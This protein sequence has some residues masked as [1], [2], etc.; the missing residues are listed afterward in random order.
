MIVV[1]M[2]HPPH[3]WYVVGIT[4]DLI[5]G[6]NSYTH[7]TGC[8]IRQALDE[9]VHSAEPGDFL[10]VHDSGHDTHLPA[11]T[12]DD[13]DTGYDECIVSSDFNLIN[14]MILALR[15]LLVVD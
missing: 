11:E 10:I 6:D 14:R 9:L 12:G 4:D 5:D 8:N 13:D 1:L 2:W 3:M 7:P 15:N